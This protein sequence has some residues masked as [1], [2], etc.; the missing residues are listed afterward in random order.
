[1]AVFINSNMEAS[2]ELYN[3]ITRWPFI[4]PPGAIAFKLRLR[5]TNEILRCFVFYLDKTEECILE[6]DEEA[7]TMY[8]GG[9]L[10]VNRR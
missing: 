1:M 5:M 4:S 10:A 2:A 8:P 7:Q 6:F 9:V 3:R